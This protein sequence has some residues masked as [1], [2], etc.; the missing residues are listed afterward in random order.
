MKGVAEAGL[1]STG[2]LPRMEDSLR[3]A[4]HSIQG[5]LIAVGH[6]HNAKRWPELV[7]AICLRARVKRVSRKR[8][9]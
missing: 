4:V 3:R 2:S 1:C 8:F 7:R 5:Q 9:S 6:I